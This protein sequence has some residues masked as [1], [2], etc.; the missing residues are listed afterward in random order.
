MFLRLFRELEPEHFA[1]T[2]LGFALGARPSSLR[3]LRRRG[4]EK[5][6][7]KETGELVFRRSHTRG[8][9]VMDSTKNAEDLTVI[10]PNELRDILAWH[11]A[12]FLVP[13][14]V[15]GTDRPNLTASKRAASDLLFPSRKGGFAPGGA[16]DKALGQVERGGWA[17]CAFG[18]ADRAPHAD[19]AVAMSAG[20]THAALPD[21]AAPTTQSQAHT[22][23]WPQRR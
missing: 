15:A 5:D 7:D 3:P 11:Q 21:E 9:E 6:Y 22:P 14:N 16:R 2:A 1:M 13:R 10:L 23:P 18:R 17:M 20:S 8:H 19:E 4:H 12:T